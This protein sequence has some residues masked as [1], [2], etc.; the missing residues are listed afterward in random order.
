MEVKFRLM[1]LP[2]WSGRQAADAYWPCRAAPAQQL[3]FEIE[4]P[5]VP[6]QQARHA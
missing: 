2:H 5:Q 4:P 6:P 3:L 1:V